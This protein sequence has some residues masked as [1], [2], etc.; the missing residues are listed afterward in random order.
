MVDKNNTPI[1]LLQEIC[2]SLILKNRI[3]RRGKGNHNLSIH[4]CNSFISF[5]L[6]CKCNKSKAFW[7]VRNSIN[8]NFSWYLK[9]KCHEKKPLKNY[10]CKL[11][12]SKH[13]QLLGRTEKM[14]LIIHYPWYR[15]IVLK[16]KIRSTWSSSIKYKAIKTVIN[17]NVNVQPHS[18]LV[19]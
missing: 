17:H 6:W 10:N 15:M 14:P 12:G 3:I 5:I 2:V 13:L 19:T 1:Q 11:L 7:S 4:F 8:H 9:Q 16:K 18:H